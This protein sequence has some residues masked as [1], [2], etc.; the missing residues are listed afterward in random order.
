MGFDYFMNFLYMLRFTFLFLLIISNN[1]LFSRHIVGGDVTYKLVSSDGVIGGNAT[2]D[3]K[4]TI[5]RDADSGGADFDQPAWLGIYYKSETAWVFIRTIERRYENTQFIINVD[6]PCVLTPANV[7]YEKT[8]YNFIVTLPIIE[9]AYQITYQRCCRTDF[10]V[11]IQAPEATG[12]TYYVEISP[13]AQ[14]VKN[15]SPVFNIFPPAVL[16]ANTYFEVDLG[17][18]DV[19]GDSLVYEFFN[20]LAGGGLRG[21]A[22]GT[23]AQAHE[24]D[25]VIPRPDNCPP[26][27]PGVIFKPPYSWDNPLD[28]NPRIRINPQTGVIFGT[29]VNHGQFVVGVRVR[30]YRDGVLIGT[31]QRDFQFNVTPCVPAVTAQVGNSVQLDVK[32]FRV[33]A[34]GEDTVTFVNNSYDRDKIQSVLWKFDIDGTIVTSEEWNG[35]I[36]FPGPGFYTG[37]LIL[38][39]EFQCKD[40]TDINVNVYPGVYALFDYEQDSCRQMPVTFV[41]S[42]YSEAGP[43]QSVNWDFGDGSTSFLLDPVH[44][45]PGPG[46]YEVK[47]VVEDQNKCK[48]EIEKTIRYFPVPD[49]IVVA[50]SSYLACEPATIK[51]FN[52]TGI[53]DER[54]TVTWDFG[55]GAT[56]NEKDPVHVYSDPGRYTVRIG[57]KSPN[58]CETQA[59]YAQWIEIKESPLA[60]FDV[61]PEILSITNPE[62][63]IN[64]KSIGGNYH[65]WNFGTGDVSFD[66]EPKYSF[67]DTGLYSILYILTADNHC[68]DT[69]IKTVDVSP[70]V[71]LFFPNAFTPNGDGIN[72]EFYPKGSFLRYMVGY[73]LTVWDRWGGMVFETED[74]RASWNGKKF[75]SGDVLPQ[76]V[77]VYNYSFR[78]ARGKIIADRGFVTLI[79]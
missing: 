27:H 15:N 17:A 39:Q 1:S 16:C 47:L 32:L 63:R 79:K 61:I 25:G 21:S 75:N 56:S 76:G 34:C 73:R 19:D 23:G 52:N 28:G 8:E 30:E 40:S 5:Y 14:L 55:D 44:L 3:I 53:I 4:F 71:N 72:D 11:N 10:I 58:G 37:K 41:N 49:D 13:E 65:F 31:I 45:F 78:T 48:D 66:F 68:T 2:Y 67:P 51:F 24:C 60:D 57:I 12:A 70:D 9:S 7:L 54:Y 20:P 42:S 22:P 74:P 6:D 69:L 29:P 38:N 62:I 77:Y 33:F 59:E 64:N 43:L 18:N 50:P 35:I 36:G 46:Q 26:P